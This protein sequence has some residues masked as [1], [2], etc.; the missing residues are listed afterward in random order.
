MDNTGGEWSKD[1]QQ[2]GVA[3]EGLIKLCR[4]IPHDFKPWLFQSRM[5]SNKQL[6]SF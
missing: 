5:L 4:N 3:V 6:N 1:P 2:I